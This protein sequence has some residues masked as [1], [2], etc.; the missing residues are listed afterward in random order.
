EEKGVKLEE[1][2]FP[3]Y[4]AKFENILKK[5][6]GKFLVGRKVSYADFFVAANFQTSVIIKPSLLDNFPSIEAHQS[7]ILGLPG[8]KEWVE[9]RPVTPF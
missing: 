2:T 1:E 6:E 8:V 4:L 5:S 3:F 9:R 7:F